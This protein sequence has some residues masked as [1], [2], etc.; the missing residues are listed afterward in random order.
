MLI[1]ILDENLVKRRWWMSD[2]G[3]GLRVG[4]YYYW[5]CKEKRD[6]LLFDFSRGLGQ[7]EKGNCKTHKLIV[8]DVNY[9]KTGGVYK[10]KLT[11]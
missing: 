5:F 8:A 9:E 6:G 11:Y 10:L 7:W 4:C 2:N 1:I 3:D